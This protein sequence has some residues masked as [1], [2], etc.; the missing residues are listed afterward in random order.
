MN[1]CWSGF[2]PELIEEEEEVSSRIDKR[3]W[4]LEDCLFITQLLLVLEREELWA[5]TTCYSCTIDQS[6]LHMETTYPR[7]G[8]DVTKS[9]Y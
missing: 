8:G 9:D 6:Y 3:D 7:S 2:M 1:T 5:T 4:E